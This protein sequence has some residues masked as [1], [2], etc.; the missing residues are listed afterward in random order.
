MVH[1]GWLATQCEVSDWQG[2]K[3]AAKV[4]APAEVELS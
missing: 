1:H 2:S 4:V 3:E